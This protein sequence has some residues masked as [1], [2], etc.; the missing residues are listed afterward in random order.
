MNGRKLVV[1]VALM[2]FHFAGVSVNAQ[3]PATTT[4]F[5]V[6]VAPMYAQPKGEFHQNVRRGFGGGGG[7]LYRLDR[8]GFL[9][10]RFDG[11]GFAYGREERTV[12][13][14][15]TVGGRVTVDVT[16]TNSFF[17]FSFGPELAVPRG[18]IRPY[19]NTAFSGLWL[20]TGSSVGGFQSSDGGQSSIG[21]T[22]FSDATRALILGGGVMVP[23]KGIVSLDTGVRYHRGGQASYLQQGGIQ[24]NPDGSITV[25]PLNSKTPYMV[26]LIGVRIRIPYDSPRPCPRFLC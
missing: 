15:E 21:T 2:I 8:S 19:V 5:T 24:D 26:Y 23:L 13:F 17:T 4:R 22:N 12:P 6:A 9:S 1:L 18:P 11:S 16:T 7:L 20:S 14:S 10:L 25:A 3:V